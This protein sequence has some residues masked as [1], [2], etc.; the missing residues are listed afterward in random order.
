[1][2]MLLPHLTRSVPYWKNLVKLVSQT[3]TI[4]QV[5]KELHDPYPYNAVFIS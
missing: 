5:Q 3:A 1:M 2:R 4:V